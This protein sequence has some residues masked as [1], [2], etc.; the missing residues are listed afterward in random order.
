MKYVST[1]SDKSFLTLFIIITSLLYF[2]LGIQGFDMMD[3]GWCATAYQQVFNE[4]ESVQY[5]FMYYLSLLIG[6]IWNYLFGWGGILSFRILAIIVKVLTALFVFKT[7][8]PY[9]NRWIVALGIWLVIC[10]SGYGLFLYHHNHLSALLVTLSAY[11]M[12]KALRT[13]DG[14]AM[15]FSGIILG[16]SLFAR[17]TNITM[18]AFVLVL[19]PYYL[20]KKD[21]K[22]VWHLFLSYVFGYVIS[23]A[24][25]FVIMF[26]LGHV[27]VFWGALQEGRIAA[28]DPESSHKLSYLVLM[29]AHNY[30]NVIKHFILLSLLPLV[31]Y[32]LNR[33]NDKVNNI[34]RETILL[35]I[36]PFYIYILFTR[37]T[38]L[39]D[40]YALST[41]VTFYYLIKGE[42]DIRYL[43]VLCIICLY[44]LPL[45]SDF[46]IHNMGENCVWLAVPFSLG[47]LYKS[48][49]L[50]Q[51]DSIKR[52]YYK[53]TFILVLVFSMMWLNSVLN[54]CYF[55]K[56]SRFEKMYLIDNKLATTFT[57][58][59]NCEM[60]NPLLSELKKYVKKDDE[61]LCF[62][63]IGTIHFL[64]QTR[65]Y[66]KNPLVWSYTPL[67]MKYQL[68]KTEI[69]N[70]PLPVI[71]RDK[72]IFPNWSSYYPDWNNTEAKESFAHKN[73]RIK[74]MNEYLDRHQYSVVWENEVFQLLLPPSKSNSNM[75]NK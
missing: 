5:L 26:L 42:K 15:L 17:V 21:L 72:S 39:F 54:T 67:M 60:L 57:T 20:E 45:G 51:S 71:V 33:Y 14:K 52:E 64:T 32:V 44:F 46:G 55:D 30:I 2:I 35:L 66:L 56:G 34:V 58:K 12:L 36:L 10:C 63:C 23:V 68:E 16:A 28:S 3:E 24:T 74:Y 13:D 73:N 65:P 22:S 27:N 69:D 9:V 7:L 47:L 6:G 50:K 41:A 75:S 11:Y 70:K 8:K 62:Q 1:L 4:P 53:F 38:V 40:V 29:Y 61:L 19:I 43:S 59:R 48:I 49:C 37:T 31:L 18:T 25:V